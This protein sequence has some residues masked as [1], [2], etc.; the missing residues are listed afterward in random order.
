MAW[1]IITWLAGFVGGLIVSWIYNNP[2][3]IKK[4]WQWFLSLFKKKLDTAA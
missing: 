2:D 1:T 3:K 4:L